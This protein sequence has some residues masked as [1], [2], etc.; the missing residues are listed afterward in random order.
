MRFTLSSLTFAV[1]VSATSILSTGSSLAA[2]KEQ[3]FPDP[4]NLKIPSIHDDASIKFDF[5]IAYVRARAKGTMSRA[6]GPTS[7]TRGSWTP[8]PI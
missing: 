5:D 7:P 8:A 1:L 2:E 3:L 6:F 4:I